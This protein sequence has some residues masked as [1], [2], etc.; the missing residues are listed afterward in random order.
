MLVLG[1]YRYQVFNHV[2]VGQRVNLSHFTG[3]SVDPVQARQCVS[4]INVHR[5]RT[6]DT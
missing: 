5:T 6:A 2:H 1:T 3:V 4:T